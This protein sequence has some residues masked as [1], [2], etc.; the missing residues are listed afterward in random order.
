MMIIVAVIIVTI[1]NN[2]NNTIM[3]LSI[4]S[5]L[6]VDLLS[7]ESCRTKRSIDCKKKYVVL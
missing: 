5:V 3:A 4:L 6:K 1:L 2:N 7:T